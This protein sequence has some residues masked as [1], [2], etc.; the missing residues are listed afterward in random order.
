[1]IIEEN[2]DN[3]ILRK[4]T[5][6]IKKID[7]NILDLAQQMIQTMEK[8]NGI[9][10]AANQVGKD[11]KMFVLPKDLLSKQIFINPEILKLSKKTKIMEEG[12]LSLPGLEKLVKRS[13]SLK[14]KA[15]DENNKEFKLKI[16]GI[17]A[18]VIQH[19][20]DHLNGILITDYE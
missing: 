3:P 8:A 11:L 6:T 2:K 18:R 12:C 10:L 14:I 16:K 20:I 4:K 9:G 1:M 7:E 17:P 13:T 19:E 15:L 5:Q